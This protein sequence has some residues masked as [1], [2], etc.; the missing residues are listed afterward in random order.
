MDSL[1]T[2]ATFTQAHEAALARALVESH[3]I[4]CF[5]MD[6]FMVAAQPLYANAIGGVK[7]RVRSVDAQQAYV[8]LIEG[9]LILPSTNERPG[10]LTRNVH[11]AAEYLQNR[12]TGRSVLWI[13]I[14][15][16][17]VMVGLSLWRL[18]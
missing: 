4:E 6:E 1:T 5:L 16:V 3:G 15:V 14:V 11:R 7:L 9:G 8:V 12:M 18:M 13:A 10:I 2:I 17:L